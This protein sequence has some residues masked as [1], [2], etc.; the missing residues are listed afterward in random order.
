MARLRVSSA[1][2]HPFVWCWR[3]RCALTLAFTAPLIVT[4]LSVPL[5]GDQVG[6][7]RWLAILA[8]FCG[9]LIILQPGSG[10]FKSAA[11]IPLISALMFAVY[12]LATR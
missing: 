3:S 6:W 12:G 4:A 10:V 2:T 11:V 8:G 9:M 7:R 5:L 1:S